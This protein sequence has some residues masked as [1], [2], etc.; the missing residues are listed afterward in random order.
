[1]LTQETKKHPNRM[2]WLDRVKGIGILFVVIGHVYVEDGFFSRIIHGLNV[3]LFFIASGYLCACKKEWERP[4]K[5][6]LF[7]KIRSILLPYFAYSG[8]V[9]AWLLVRLFV[10]HYGSFYEIMHCLADVFCLEGISVLW[11]LSALF[12]GEILFLF[13]MKTVNYGLKKQK[14]RSGL[15]ALTAALF[16]LFAVGAYCFSRFIG[17][18]VLVSYGAAGKLIL[19]ASR[20]LGRGVMAGAFMLMGTFI[21]F[22]E[23]KN[24]K[25]REDIGINQ[26]NKKSE[27]SQ[28]SEKNSKN[29]NS[30]NRNSKNRN[31]KNLAILCFTLFLSVTGLWYN[32]LRDFHYL[33]FG[34]FPLYLANGF[35]GFIAVSLIGRLL[36]HD[37]ILTFFG[38]SSLVIMATHLIF[39][40]WINIMAVILSVPAGRYLGDEREA[41]LAVLMFLELCLLLCR[42]RMKKQ[43]LEETQDKM[44]KN[45]KYNC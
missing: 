20:I 45:N 7:K 12:V 22:K 36:S 37:R 32:G 1:M 27:E 9:M 24:E 31:G 11:F 18:P 35:F 23:E 29:K 30:K 26:E 16:T 2:D 4:G 10:F 19:K 15:T 38:R 21:R 17:W 44:H 13:S 14:K 39:L 25:N 33:S 6:L 28:K 41:K 8:A 34:C 3:P 40:D 42:K 5:Q 43:K